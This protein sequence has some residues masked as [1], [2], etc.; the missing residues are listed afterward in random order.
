MILTSKS[1]IFALG[2]VLTIVGLSLCGAGEGKKKLTKNMSYCYTRDFFASGKDKQNLHTQQIEDKDNFKPTLIHR[3]FI[4][5]ALLVD[6]SSLIK[7]CKA[8]IKFII[9]KKL[10]L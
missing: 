8:G 9:K 2:F 1:N 5:R 3:I 10:K 7:I 4:P 6:N